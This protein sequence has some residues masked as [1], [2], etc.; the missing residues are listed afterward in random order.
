MKT[1]MITTAFLALSNIAQAS[2]QPKNCADFDPKE[3]KC[4]N[5]APAMTLDGFVEIN[6]IKSSMSANG[7]TYKEEVTTIC[8][9][10]IKV[11]LYQITLSDEETDFD[12]VSTNVIPLK[13]NSKCSLRLNNTD[14]EIEINPQALET[15]LSHMTQNK[16]YNWLPTWLQTF[17]DK[18]DSTLVTTY[19]GN[20]LITPMNNSTQINELIEWHP[21]SNISFF[22]HAPG[23]TALDLTTQSQCIQ[24]EQSGYCSIHSAVTAK[25][26]I[27]SRTK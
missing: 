3:R 20:L 21:V 17:F 8:K 22:G 15:S 13:E 12:G 26:Y 10:A 4:L 19:V 16:V 1:L 11:P 18:P 6:L 24:K 7:E 9:K 5:W 25:F 14:F 27:S 2:G 23:V